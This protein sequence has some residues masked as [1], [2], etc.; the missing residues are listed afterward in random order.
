MESQLVHS[1]TL[2][3]ECAHVS[4]NVCVPD[5]QSSAKDAGVFAENSWDLVEAWHFCTAGGSWLP[6]TSL[7]CLS[8]ELGHKDTTLDFGVYETWFLFF[9]NVFFV[10]VVVQMKMARV[11]TKT[12][13]HSVSIQ[14]SKP[15]SS[16][17]LQVTYRNQYACLE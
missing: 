2:V 14:N 9:G 5:H 12:S 13:V 8:Q 3:P 17:F 6:T 4:G 1:P 7:F 10:L 11:R 16:H 15:Y